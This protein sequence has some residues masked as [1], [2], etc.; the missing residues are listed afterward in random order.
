MHHQ[1]HYENIVRV[2]CSKE[3]ARKWAQKATVDSRETKEHLEERIIDFIKSQG[4]YTSLE[5]IRENLKISDKL[6]Y[7]R[8]ISIPDLNYRAGVSKKP[9][10]NNNKTY[11]EL[12]EGYKNLLLQ[13]KNITINEA[14]RKLDV[15]VDYFRKVGLKVSAVRK[16]IGIHTYAS[17]TRDEVISI[18]VPFIQQQGMYTLFWLFVRNLN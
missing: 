1:T 17:K 14:A 15:S 5:Q 6:V 3:C 13:N 9:V 2:T 4:V 8:G 7:K 18:V 11:E 10:G 16:A 12:F